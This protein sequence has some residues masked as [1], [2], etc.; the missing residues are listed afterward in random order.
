MVTL[1]DYRE[2]QVVPFRICYV[3][4]GEKVL[5]HKQGRY[6]SKRRCENSDIRRSSGQYPHSATLRGDGISTGTA[7]CFK[8][9]VNKSSEHICFS[10][11]RNIFGQRT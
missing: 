10:I 2:E 11:S 5:K 9:Q 4:L 6:C 1:C 8:L 7:A 3:S